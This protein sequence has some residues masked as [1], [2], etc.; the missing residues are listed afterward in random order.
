MSLTQNTHLWY[1]V[2]D[3][4]VTKARLYQL[5]VWRIQ[6]DPVSFAVSGWS[7]CRK[8]KGPVGRMTQVSMVHAPLGKPTRYNSI[9]EKHVNLV[10]EV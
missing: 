7:R 1:E 4:Y 2:E 8:Y 3:N 6:Y 10:Q 5:F 9:E